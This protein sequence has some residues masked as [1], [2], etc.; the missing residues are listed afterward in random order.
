V[1]EASSTLLERGIIDSLGVVELLSFVE[2]TF[3]VTAADEEITEENFGSL[4]SI[5]QFVQRKR[6]VAAV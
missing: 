2:E 5:A 1:V 4:D 6:A 3:A